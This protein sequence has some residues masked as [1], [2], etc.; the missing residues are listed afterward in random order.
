MARSSHIRAAVFD[1]SAGRTMVG[2]SIGFGPAPSPP[3][4][5]TAVDRRPRLGGPV[6]GRR[7]QHVGGDERAGLAAEHVADALD[8]RPH[9]DDGG[10]ADGDADEEKQQAP[11]RRS[12]LAHRHPQHEGHREITSTPRCSTTRPSR[13]TRRA[14][15]IAASSASWVTR[16]S[17]E[18]ADRMDVA[19]QIHDV[20]AVGAIE[21]AGR[22]VGQQDRRIVGQRSRERHALLLTARQL[23]RIVVSPAGQAD[24]VEPGPGPGHGVR[25]AGN[26]HR[27]RDVFERRQRRNE[28]KELEDEADLLAAQP[29]QT[30]LVEPRDVGAVDRDRSGARGV[31][32]RDEPEQRRLAAARGTDDG[33]KLTGRNGGRERMENRQRLGAAHHRLRHVVE[34]DH[35][36]GASPRGAAAF[37]FSLWSASSAPARTRVAHGPTRDREISTPQARRL[38][39]ASTS[40]CTIGSPDS[41]KTAMLRACSCNRRRRRPIW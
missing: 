28:M 24:L 30:V 39:F 37:Q 31:E 41:G 26:L 15:A 2:V 8:D 21:I 33:D 5:Q 6:A 32:P 1:R 40:R 20:P 25:R 4:R 7:N 27:H 35:P 29:G 10:H 38:S 12:G 13:S 19:H 23:R 34:L 3:P 11:P 16:T 36:G 14:S 22:L 18:R 9:R 17:V